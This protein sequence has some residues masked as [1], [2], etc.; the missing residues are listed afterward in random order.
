MYRR[1]LVS[2]ALC[3]IVT[4]TTATVAAAQAPAV[5]EKPQ[6]F[7]PPST[8][9]AA[10]VTPM[11]QVPDS[12]VAPVVAATQSRSFL[13]HRA[14]VAEFIAFQSKLAE[15]KLAAA[16]TA[17]KAELAAAHLGVQSSMFQCIR[18]AESGDRY[19]ITSGDY[20][21]L[22]STWQAFSN[23]WSPLGSWSVPGDAPVDVHDMVAYH[24]YPVGGGYGGWHNHCT[25][26]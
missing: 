8:V 7:A 3:V 4:L 13:M 17:A 24:L 5:K 2:M 14:H 16:R 9:L 23:V 15:Q 6:T 10:F 20:G 21:I 19:S 11:I 12:A 22:I 18:T 26:T 25:G 1:H